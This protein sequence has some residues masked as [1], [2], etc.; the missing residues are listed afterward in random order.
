MKT[1]VTIRPFVAWGFLS[2]GGLL[3]GSPAEAQT[4]SPKRGLAY[5]IKSV[6]DLNVLAPGLTWWYNWGPA[7]AAAVASTYPG[8]GL[9][10][11][12]MQWNKDLDG[13][14]V[15]ADKLAA[16]VPAGAKYLLGFNEPNFRLQANLTPTQAA[17]LWPVL[18]DVA[19]RK[20]LK[21]VSPALNYCG[22][23]VAENG[24][25]YYSPTQYLDAFFA[26]CPSC[27]VDYIA[28]HTYV[29]EERYLRDKIAELKKYNKPIWLTEFSCGDMDHSQIT[30]NLQKKYLTDAV[31]YLENEPAVFRYSWFSGRNSEIPY[32]NLLGADGQLTDL[33]QLYLN[34]PYAGSP[35]LANRLTPVAVTASSTEKAEVAP[36]NAIDGNILSRWASAW[37]D[38]Q[39]L[40][41]DFGSVQKIA[42][43][44][45]SWE[46]GYAADYQLQ[47]STDGT[48]WTTIQTVIN[49]DGGVD[50][51]TGLA[52]SGRYLRVYGTRRGTSY[53]Y[54]LWEIN[55]YGPSTVAPAATPTLIQ[56]ESSSTLSGVGMET[57]TDTGGGQDVGW[58]DAGDKLTYPSVTFPTTGTYSIEYRAASPN[59]G[60]L[61]A[62]LGGTAL[63][64][65]FTL[66]ATGGWQTWQTYTQTVIVTAGTYTLN[67][68]A[69][70]GGWNL[71]WLRIT[72]STATARTA[73]T[74]TLTTAVASTDTELE[75]Y[76]N[77]ATS[78]LQLRSAR[79]LAGS[80]YQILNT[81][82]QV[83][84]NGAAEEGNLDVSQLTPGLY[85]LRLTV[86]GQQVSRRFVK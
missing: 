18:Q 45:L 62:D 23:C 30:L 65:T 53:G 29:C 32:I 2:V 17:A 24:V 6:A 75:V 28:V 82:G 66:P 56:A 63:G 31:N 74:A 20:N 7:P 33:G 22:D 81:W 40:Q 16:K 51:I 69:V 61:A 77:P 12:P 21:L 50:D 58:I 83:V 14:T 54:S 5:D 37:S 60:S 64:T 19:Q 78:H 84:A 67:L 10:F 38:P 15:T 41:L 27:Q 70:T 55:A 25:T 86:E 42:H 1:P 13:G 49:G 3:L 57:T 79:S 11:V 35:L 73:A 9:E 43:V 59:G 52:G 80:R 44:R 76:P 26:A 47:T 71:N 34:Q 68:K 8:L 48:S 72:S 85:T 36:A 39:Y 4:K 46:A